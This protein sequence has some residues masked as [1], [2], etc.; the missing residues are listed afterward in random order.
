V[1]SKIR[2]FLT[3]RDLLH[4]GDSVIAALSGGAD[5]VALLHI[6]ISLEEYNLTIC[7]AHFNHM[8]RGDE[9]DRDE[10][11]CRELCERLGIPFYA[12]RADVPAQAK[13]RGESLETCARRLRYDYLTG[14]SGRLDA[15]IATAHHLGD[16]TETVLMNLVR[17]SGIAGL[18]GIP[19]RRGRIIRPLLCVTRDEIETFCRENGLAYVTDS[20]NLDD[21]CTRNRF[22]WNIIPRLREMNPSLDE[23]IMRMTEVMRDADDYLNKI[24]L[25]EL[26]KQ[27]TAYGCRCEGLLQLDRAVLRYAIRVL[28]DRYGAPMDYEHTALVIDA[29]RCGGSVDLGEGYRAVCAQGILRI[30][31]PDEP[32][33]IPINDACPI[34]ES[35]C[36]VRLMIKDGKAYT[37]G[38]NAEVFCD[39]IHK[40]FFNNC[41]P[42]AIITDDTTVRPRRGGDTF[43]DARRGLTKP[44]RKLM[45][46]LKIP[47]ERRDGLLLVAQGSVVL[48]LEGVGTSQQANMEP[49]YSGEVYYMNR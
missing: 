28:A 45:N 19:P 11:F 8:I 39:K 16:N 46:E 37:A 42:C 43:S 1:I 4:K 41:I 30:V 48:W 15:K 2:S 23:A 21:A 9:A 14:L 13:E 33:A 7:A 20:T 31:T 6:L 22:R 18:S 17:G 49:S 27:Q 3:G 5:S 34:G 25:E 29:M 40:K 47:R 32:A 24:S 10:A 26:N 12:G 44:L 36:A 35:P 38:E